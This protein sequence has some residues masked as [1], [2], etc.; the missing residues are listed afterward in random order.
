MEDFRSARWTKDKLNTK[1]SLAFAKT[2]PLIVIENA[3]PVDPEKKTV[4]MVASDGRVAYVFSPNGCA[5]YY[6]FDDVADE[7]IALN[8]GVA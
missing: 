1:L 7:R 3:T 8:K 2:T 6:E 5:G 4:R